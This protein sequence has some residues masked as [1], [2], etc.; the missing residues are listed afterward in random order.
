[1]KRR[2]ERFAKLSAFVR[3]LVRSGEFSGVTAAVG[4]GRSILW[5]ESAG[6]SRARPVTPARWA[7]RWDLA[8]LAKPQVATLALVLDGLGRLPLSIRVGDVF[9]AAAPTIA[10]VRLGALLRHRSG[11][12]AWTPLY[13]RCASSREALA[14]LLSGVL[15]T[16]SSSRVVYSDLGYILWSAAAEHAL[17]DDLEVLLRQFVWKPLG[18]RSMSGPPGTAGDV[19]QARL[20]NRR[21]QEFAARQG[22]DVAAVAAA[23]RGRAQDGNARFLGGIPGHAGAFGA[24]ADLLALAGEW[25]SP[26]RLLSR[27]QVQQ[28]LQGGGEYALGWA[29]RR[30]RGT[31]GPA[32]GPRAFGQV[33]ST[34]TSLWIDPDRRRAYVLIGHR[35][36][37][38]D[39]KP[40]RRRFHRLAV[41]ALG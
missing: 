20:D 4:D 40:T 25:L 5:R 6:L 36:S 15:R 24:A 39:L 37:W 1:M 3:G 28:A 23:P 38:A 18:M 7:T 2:P 12:M 35:T 9:D 30:I 14:L 33:G 22:L 10:R 31:A 27:R 8:S 19:A 13:A 26:G 16:E 32:L 29:R 17:A 34:G 21:E 41:E 11:L